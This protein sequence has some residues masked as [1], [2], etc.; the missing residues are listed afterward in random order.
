MGDN[1]CDD[2]SDGLADV[3]GVL[4]ADSDGDGDAEGMS[5]SQMNLLLYPG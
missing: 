4:V 5:N 1:D 2:D 3:V